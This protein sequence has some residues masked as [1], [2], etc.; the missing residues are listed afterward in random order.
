MTTLSRQVARNAFYGGVARLLT[1]LVAL[2][3]TPYLLT[4]LGEQRFAVWALVGVVTGAFATLDLSLKAG[5]VRFLAEALARHDRRGVASVIAIGLAFYSTFSIVV[6]AGYVALRP[7]ILDLLNIPSDLRT[8][9]SQVFAIGLA[10][11]LISAV[12]SVFA[13]VCDAKQRMDLTHRLGL[14]ALIVSTVLTVVAVERGFGLLGVALAQLLGVALFYGAAIAIARNLLGAFGLGVGGLRWSWFKRLV[15]YGSL[16]HLSTACGIVNRQFDKLVLSSWAGLPTVTSYEV[17]AR[18]ATNA[19][20]FQP[21]LASSLLP[22]ASHLHSLGHRRELIDLYVRA[23]RYLFMLGIPPFVFLGV[24][25]S[26]IM[27]AWLGR[28]EPLAATVLV[29]LSG[30][31][32]VNSISNAMAFVCQGIGRPDVQAR[33]SAIQLAVNV[34][35]SLTLL[36]LIGPL[37]APLGTSLALVVGAA[38][39]AYS[40]HSLLDLSS[41]D[42]FREAA[43]IPLVASLTAGASGYLVASGIT[44]DDR[45]GALWS[46]TVNGLVFGIVYLAVCLRTALLSRADLRRLLGALYPGSGASG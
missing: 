30:G 35:S 14:A 18:L 22:A 31:Y 45:L 23:S 12:L 29:V 38:V 2:F 8:I 24:N 7:L 9:A 13:A 33:Q 6:A 21:F 17:A 43:G 1:L 27:M 19:G 39:F 46:L 20:S 5:F 32:M 36:V 34:A 42:L 16:L 11:F 25:S 15:H 4:R 28:A 41:L 3:L 44:A 40:F 26:V 37:G 10:S